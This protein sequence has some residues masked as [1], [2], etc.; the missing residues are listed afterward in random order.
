MKKIVALLM[1]FL[2]ALS[3]CHQQVQSALPNPHHETITP[4]AVTLPPVP[5]VT[6]PP[7]SPDAGLNMSD[8]G[9]NGE[10][11]TPLATGARAPYNGVLFNGPA[12]AYLQV[13]F[14]GQAQR[15]LIDRQHDVDL[16][17]ARYNA[18]IATLRLALNTQ[19]HTDQ[20]ILNGRD[21][22]IA[23]LNRL[24]TQEAHRGPDVNTILI[25]GGAGLI[26]GAIAVGALVLG[27]R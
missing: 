11:I 25:S 2:T 20:V 8:A 24:L 17:M 19:E 9:Q 5:N 18:D 15:C 3:A 22:D 12:V 16:V 10:L 7:L 6:L 13:E 27:L 14:R 21:Q 23:N 4:V 26:I 1:V